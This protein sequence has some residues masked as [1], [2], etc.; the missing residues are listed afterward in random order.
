M[1]NHTYTICVK[2]GQKIQLTKSYR[3]HTNHKEIQVVLK[4]FSKKKYLRFRTTK[5][6]LFRC[7]VNFVNIWGLTPYRHYL[8]NLETTFRS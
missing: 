6:D 5:R 2:V 8:S 7:R 3:H 4:S 1:R